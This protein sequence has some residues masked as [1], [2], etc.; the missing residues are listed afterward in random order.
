MVMVVV[1]VVAMLVGIRYEFVREGRR[2]VRKGR[3]D[4]K[5]SHAMKLVFGQR[6]RTKGRNRWRWVCQGV[7]FFK[8]VCEE[9][10]PRYS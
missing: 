2:V 3:R 4:R 10:S 7:D 6:M 1:V 9:Y 8:I 5:R